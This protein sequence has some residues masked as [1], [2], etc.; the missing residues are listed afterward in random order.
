MKKI[1][2]KPAIMVENFMLSEYI[3][4]CDQSFSNNMD[5]DNWL[6]DLKGAFGV[7]NGEYQCQRKPTPGAD[8]D[9]G[10]GVMICYHTATRVVFSS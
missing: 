7:F 3:A 2:E 6:N 8:Y 4:S 1:Y 9:L 10:G 5:L